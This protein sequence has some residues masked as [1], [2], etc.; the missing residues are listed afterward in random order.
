MIETLLGGLFG[1]ISRMVPEVLTWIDKRNERAHELA[2]FDKQLEADRLRSQNAITEM[3]TQGQIGLDL[4]G[5]QALTESIKSQGQLTGNS[6]I[7]GIN[8]LVRP[9]L[10]FWWVIILSTAAFVC[11]YLLLVQSGLPAAAAVVQLWGA[12]EKAIVA[13]I[14]NFWFLDRVIRRQQG[15]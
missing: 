7:D 8:S 9:V 5:V 10:T 11:Q 3:K 6:I 15:V 14:L 1:G 4:A 12:P 13:S 2:M